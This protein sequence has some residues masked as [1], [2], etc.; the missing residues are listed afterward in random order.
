MKRK[1]VWIVVIILI[2]AIGLGWVLWKQ[3]A[4]IARHILMYE[5]RS[6]R[7][8]IPDTLSPGTYRDSIECDSRV[9]TFIV[10]VPPSYDSRSP[11][12]VVLMFH[13]RGG[14]GMLF[15]ASGMDMVADRERFIVVYPNAFPSDGS[16]NDGGGGTGAATANI[17]DVA[18]VSALIDH[19]ESKANVDPKRIYAA[20]M[21]NGAMLCHRLGCELSD[22]I[23]A[24][25][26]VSGTIMIDACNPSRPVPV[27]MVHGTADPLVTWDGSPGTGRPHTSVPRTVEM[28]LEADGCE[29]TANKPYMDLIEVHGE[30]QGDCPDGIDIVLCTVESGGHD[31]PVNDVFNVNAMLWDFFRDHPMD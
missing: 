23:A 6:S 1:P 31:W 17:D 15:E 18:F 27:I 19:L 10:H 4:R 26:A 22:K 9:R 14:S 3:R 25:G 11:I 21:S 20:G 16:W 2:L 5:E 24:I 13:G 8:V 7:S 12:P 29:K 28:W 30:Y